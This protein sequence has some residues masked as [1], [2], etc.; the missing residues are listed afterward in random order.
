MG[1]YGLVWGDGGGASGVET[2]TCVGEG[3]GG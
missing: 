2:E 3:G 1:G